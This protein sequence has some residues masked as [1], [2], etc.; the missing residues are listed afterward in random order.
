MK[1]R[2][3]KTEGKYHPYLSVFEHVLGPMGPVEQRKLAAD[4]PHRSS[5]CVVGAGQSLPRLSL[6]ESG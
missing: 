4:D 3:N 5:L 1:R 2:L 6:A